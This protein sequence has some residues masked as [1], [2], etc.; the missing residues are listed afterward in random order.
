MHERIKEIYSRMLKTDRLPQELLDEHA[1][2]DALTGERTAVNR[3]GVWPTIWV[4]QTIAR[5]ALHITVAADGTV[6]FKPNRKP[7]VPVQEGETDWDKVAVGSYVE[8]TARKNLGGGA[9]VGKFVGLA[10]RGRLL[11]NVSPEGAEKVMHLPRKEIRL[12]ESNEEAKQE[13]KQEA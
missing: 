6:T 9:P 8:L 7:A 13:A 10:D 3:Q 12:M 11:I 5:R 4:L 2:W 1:D